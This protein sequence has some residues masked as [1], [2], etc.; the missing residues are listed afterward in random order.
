M[1]MSNTQQ[2]REIKTAL[3]RQRRMTISLTLLCVPAACG[4]LRLAC[5]YRN[6]M[7]PWKACWART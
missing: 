4:S 7:G 6:A 5:L 2:H 1:F 3:V